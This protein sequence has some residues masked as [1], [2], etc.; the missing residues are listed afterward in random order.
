MRVTSQLADMDLEVDT[1]TREGDLI[2]VQTA[3]GAGIETRI[4]I[5]PRDAARILT[6][7]LRSPALLAY[8]LALPVLA[9]RARRQEPTDP[10]DPWTH[11]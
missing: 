11:M 10:A 1:I 4:E 9:W 6:R 7:A 8:V 5:G 2:V 3:R